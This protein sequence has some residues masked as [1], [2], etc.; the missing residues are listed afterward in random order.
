MY[1]IIKSSQIDAIIFNKTQYAISFYFFLT[2]SIELNAK[3]S[4]D[5]NLIFKLKQL[6]T[7][8]LSAHIVD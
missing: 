7:L 6:N 2:M 4:S 1:I 8:T 5:Q 3:L